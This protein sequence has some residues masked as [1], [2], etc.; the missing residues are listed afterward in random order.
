MT[1]RYVAFEGIDGA[2]KTTVARRVAERLRADGDE[3]IFFREPGG[4]PVGEEIR[5]VLLDPSGT[6][7]AWPEAMLFAAQ[8]AQLAVDVIAPALSEGKIVVSD[9]SVYSS[10]AYQGGA[11][12]LG[13]EQ[14]RKVNAAG[15]GEYWPEFVVLLHLD[16]ATG[17]GREDGPDRISVSGLEF[18]QRVAD[19]Y[20]RLAAAEPE[21]FIL[22]D[23]SLPID[24]VVD[25]AVAALR[26]RW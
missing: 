23:A 17:L 10:L 12:G 2:G 21:K 5:H 18:Q 14:V 24:D 4:T 13:I 15:L 9:R 22:V 25:S 1:R 8:R 6:M 20:D 16:A 7:A 26:S 11:R 3:V 19:A